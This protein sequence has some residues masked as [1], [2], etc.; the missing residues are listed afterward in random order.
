FEIL[1][2]DILI[3]EQLNPWLIE[4][5]RS[6][7]FNTDQQ[8]DQQ[9]KYNLLTDT[10]RLLNIKP[11]DKSRVEKQQKLTTRKRLYSS[12][13][14]QTRNWMYKSNSN[15]QNDKIHKYF[16]NNRLSTKKHVNHELFRRDNVHLKTNYQ[17]P[18]ANHSDIDYLKLINDQDQ[19]EDRKLSWKI[20][21]L[22]Q[23]LSKIR[24]QL[25]LEFYEHHN[26]GN[27]HRIFPSDNS[28]LQTKYASLIMTSFKQFLYSNHNDILNEIKTTYLNPITVSKHCIVFIEFIEY[29]Y[30]F[31]VM[32]FI[33]IKSNIL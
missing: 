10:I 14:V 5:N 33:S 6:P 3:D 30:L 22:K 1:G 12:H 15:I 32:H 16:D 24:Q 11:S 25:S 13:S 9:I 18:F 26:C 17:S 2:F 19:L 8:L 29:V 31:S 27:W 21:R 23:Q 20:D 4:V 7:S 28:T